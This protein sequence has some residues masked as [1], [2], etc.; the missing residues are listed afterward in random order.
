LNCSEFYHT[1]FFVQVRDEQKTTSICARHS[2]CSQGIREAAQKQAPEQEL[3]LAT[4]SAEHNENEIL[5][6]SS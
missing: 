2:G 3:C 4:Q 6:S 1:A 5:L